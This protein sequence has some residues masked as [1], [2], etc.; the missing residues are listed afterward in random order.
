MDLPPLLNLDNINDAISIY[1]SLLEQIPLSISARNFIDFAKT[2]KR[3]H[4]KVG[5][6]PNVSLFE[7]VNRTMTDLIILFGVRKLLLDKHINNIILPFDSYQVQYGSSNNAKYDVFAEK[8]GKKLIGEA[9]N[10]SKTFFQAKKA[11]MLQKL[12]STRDNDTY[13]VILCNSDAFG[14]DYSSKLNAKNEFLI[15]VDVI[16]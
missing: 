8:D 14:D 10:V 16:L 9:F 7:T 11:K 4:V 1:K 15:P 5:P 13:I 6:Y 2:I 12:R 3:E